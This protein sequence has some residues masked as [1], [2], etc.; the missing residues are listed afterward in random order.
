M[1]LAFIGNSH[2]SQ[3]DLTNRYDSIYVVGASIKGLVNPDS[4][5]QFKPKIETFIAN[6]PDHHLVFFL[7]QV[8]IEFGYYY[9]CIVDNIK[10]DI[11][12]FYDDLINKYVS[13]LK[14]LKCPFYVLSINPTTITDTSHIFNICFR[15]NNGK[16]GFYS[17]NNCA[18]SLDERV[19]G[20]LN[21]SYE[22]RF[23]HSKKFNSKLRRKCEENGFIYIDFWPVVVADNRI[24]DKYSHG[25]TD[26]HLKFGGDTELLDF[27]LDKI[28]QS[29]S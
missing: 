25:T 29:Q 22:V 11:D 23:E 21:D 12:T 15:C 28:T 16:D 5:L 19:R 14:E 18:Y 17:D 3:F 2:L 4:K 7:G 10:Y 1:K 9:K 13:Y 24:R 8:D 20:L 27:V 6:N 26:H